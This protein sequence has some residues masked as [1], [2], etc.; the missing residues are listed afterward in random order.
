MLFGIHVVLNIVDIIL[1]LALD[2]HSEEMKALT[3]GQRIIPA[4]FQAATA[5]TCG[6]T[7]FNPGNFHPAVQLNVMRKYRLILLAT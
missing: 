2:V 6:A 1:I 4:M 5:R 3:M 7:V